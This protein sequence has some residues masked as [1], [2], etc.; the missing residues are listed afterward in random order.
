MQSLVEMNDTEEKGLNA[1]LNFDDEVF[2]VVENTEHTL[3]K[4]SRS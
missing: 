4:L 1:L 2:E 3:G